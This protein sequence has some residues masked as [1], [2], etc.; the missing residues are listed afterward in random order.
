MIPPKCGSWSH[1]PDSVTCK[2]DPYILIGGL[3]C[4]IGRPCK[5][6]IGWWHARA[7]K[8]WRWTIT[9]AFKKAVLYDQF[10]RIRVQLTAGSPPELY[11]FSFHNAHVELV[12]YQG[13]GLL[14][15][16]VFDGNGETVLR[17]FRFVRTT[18]PKQIDH[19]VT[20]L[21]RETV[22]LTKKGLPELG[23]VLAYWD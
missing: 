13:L 10:F 1:I 19:E 7:P 6:F 4:R 8:G 16:R 14:A 17:T 21:R 9:D 23:G 2:D 20:N 18:H 5:R 11:G 15:C 12:N 22:A 3:G